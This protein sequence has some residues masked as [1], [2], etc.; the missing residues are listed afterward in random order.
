MQRLFRGE[1]SSV[2]RAETSGG[3]GVWDEG[4]R[5]RDGREQ[6]L[7]E[8]GVPEKTSLSIFG[9]LRLLRRVCTHV[10]NMEL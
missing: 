2:P 9:L 8:L 1:Y 4:R 6:V 5:V 3:T 10:T 7:V